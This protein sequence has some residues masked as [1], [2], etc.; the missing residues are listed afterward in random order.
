MGPFNDL[1]T[2]D[3][4]TWKQQHPAQ[5]PPARQQG[6]LIYAEA[7]QQSILFAG[8]SVDGTQ[9]LGDTWA[10]NGTGWTQISAEG[11]PATRYE[12]VAYDPDQQEII[13][14]AAPGNLKATPPVT[15]VSQTWVWK[16]TRWTLWG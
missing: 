16:G 4:T 7:L 1:W 8:L 2:W 9:L 10:W 14:Y 5:M 15:P 13:V 12:S 11:A 3:G 6:K